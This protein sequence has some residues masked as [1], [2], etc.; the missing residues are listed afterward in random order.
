MTGPILLL[1]ATH[2]CRRAVKVMPGPLCGTWKFYSRLIAKL[3]P[4]APA[5]GGGGGGY[6]AL[7]VVEVS[8]HGD[9]CALHLRLAQEGLG[10]LPHLGQHHARDL[11]GAEL[12]GLILVLDCRKHTPDSFS[13]QQAPSHR[14]MT[15]AMLRARR[16]YLTSLLATHRSGI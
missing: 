4:L 5:R 14:Q 16:I 10:R 3:G 1:P 9:H 11:L 12:L 13:M 15:H 8:R 7:R 6:L 2:A